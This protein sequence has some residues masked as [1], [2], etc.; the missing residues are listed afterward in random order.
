MEGDCR[1]AYRTLGLSLSP[2]EI[3]LYEINKAFRKT[4]FRCIKMNNLRNFKLICR[5]VVFLR[6]HHTSTV[7]NYRSAAE[8][9]QDAQR[10]HKANVKFD[11]LLDTHASAEFIACYDRMFRRSSLLHPCNK[12]DIVLHQI[13]SP[14]SDNPTK[15]LAAFH[16][17]NENTKSLD[18][19]GEVIASIPEKTYIK[20]CPS[21][22]FAKLVLWIA[23]D[24]ARTTKSNVISKAIIRQKLRNTFDLDTD[25]S[26]EIA[27][28]S[29]LRQQPKWIITRAGFKAA[30]R[31]FE[32]KL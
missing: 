30:K 5:A 32:R 18:A 4:A 22:G 31:L 3:D 9:M 28:N 24:I 13:S 23:V 27:S 2:S 1:A 17:V 29:S 8:R 10:E 14:Q 19:S 25:L 6:Q 21:I 11:S 16:T 26:Q 20:P 15:K 12:E 7:V